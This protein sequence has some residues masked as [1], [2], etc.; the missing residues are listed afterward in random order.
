MRLLPLL[1]F[2]MI[3]MSAPALALD[4]EN[5][6]DSLPSTG[7]LAGSSVG[8]YGHTGFEGAWGGENLD[9]K[10]ASP[11]SASVSRESNKNWT[12]NVFNNSE[13]EYRLS[14]VV[15]QVDERSK[16]LKS[17][18]IS[19][20]LKGGQSVERSLRGHVLAS[21]ATVNLKRWKKVEKPL[22]RSE[23]Q[24]QIDAKKAEIAE[25]EKQLASLGA[26][27]N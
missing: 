9:G 2:S 11:I 13:D 22:D 23:I 5:G 26:T 27:T 24:A 20:T 17:N 3:L 8:G 6:A 10:E 25:L 1:S 7:R 18:P 12:V 21:H 14:L 19:V 16:R 4:G 15:E